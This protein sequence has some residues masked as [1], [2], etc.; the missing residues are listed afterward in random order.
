MVAL[1]KNKTQ[2]AVEQ[3]LVWI[4]CF[5]GVVNTLLSISTIW[6]IL[7]EISV[8]KIVNMHKCSLHKLFSFLRYTNNFVD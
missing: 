6:L 5:F 3:V 8:L 4:Y 2:Y 1:V 7:F